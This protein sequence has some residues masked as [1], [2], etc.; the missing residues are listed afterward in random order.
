MN[1]ILA[2][3]RAAE[4]VK[5]APPPFSFNFRCCTQFL[6]IYPALHGKI[7]TFCRAT[8]QRITKGKRIPFKSRCSLTSNCGRCRNLRQIDVLLCDDLWFEGSKRILNPAVLMWWHNHTSEVHEFLEFFYCVKINSWNFF[9]FNVSGCARQ[10]C[11]R[12]KTAASLHQIW[13]ILHTSLWDLA[14]SLW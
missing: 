12:G 7:G 3:F 2:W 6:K 11:R 5:V 4:K 8:Y 14:V 10:A 1:N 9:C 13:T